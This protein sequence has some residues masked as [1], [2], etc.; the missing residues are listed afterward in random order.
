MK[1]QNINL[2]QK[3]LEETKNVIN[4]NIN[5]FKKLKDFIIE[6]S[7]NTRILLMFRNNLVITQY[8]DSLL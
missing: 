7:D 1:I 2:T 4:E 5:K 8:L 3:H 6:L